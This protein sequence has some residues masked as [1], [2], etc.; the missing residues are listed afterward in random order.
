MV[1]CDCDGE[2]SCVALA[3]QIIERG[4]RVEPLPGA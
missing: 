1:A 4:P 3:L 2:V